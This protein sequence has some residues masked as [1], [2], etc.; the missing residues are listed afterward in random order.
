M[1]IQSRYP[2][3]ISVLA[4]SSVAFTP[5]PLSPPML[6]FTAETA[7]QQ[8]KLESRFDALL[9]AENLRDWMQ[10]ATVE[11]IYVGS[12]HNKEMADWMVE[13]FRTW[14]YEAELA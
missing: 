13:R 1:K 2:I 6:G 4:V 3:L 9:S 10:L 14:G 7:A 11:P 12:P 5:R 8:L